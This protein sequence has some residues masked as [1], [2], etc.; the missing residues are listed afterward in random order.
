MRRLNMK[1]EDRM[2]L[3]V[4]TAGCL[5]LVFCALFFPSTLS[6][7][8]TLITSTFSSSGFLLSRFENIHFYLFYIARSILSQNSHLQG[9]AISRHCTT[10]NSFKLS[11]LI[12]I[13]NPHLLHFPIPDPKLSQLLQKKVTYSR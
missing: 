6:P 5:P 3:S 11:S 10:S 4:Q 13:L 1:I 7:P 12:L 8:A 2:K 9:L